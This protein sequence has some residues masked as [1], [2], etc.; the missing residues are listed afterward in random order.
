M[1]ATVSEYAYIN[2][3]RM[4][5][6]NLWPVFERINEEILLT[7]PHAHVV[8]WPKQ[9]IISFGVGPAKLSQHYLFI[10]IQKKNLNLGF[11]NGTSISDPEKLLEGHGKKL[12]YVKLRTTEEALAPP[13]LA[14]IHDAILNFRVHTKTAA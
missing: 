7:H 10:S 1:V 3:I 12:R 11:Y 6:P 2:F 9:R 13:V 14:L 5:P 4:T 8:G